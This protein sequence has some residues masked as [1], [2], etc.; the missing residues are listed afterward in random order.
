L[1]STL[2]CDGT[3]LADT[4]TLD[5]LTTIDTTTAGL[6]IDKGNTGA[7]IFQILFGF[8][9]AAQGLV[10]VTVTG[11]GTAGDVFFCSVTL[12]TNDDWEIIA[13]GEMDVT[14]TITVELNDKTDQTADG[15]GAPDANVVC[16]VFDRT[17]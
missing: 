11:A 16:I 14:G 6:R 9:L 7:T 10:D 2:R 3:E 13:L 12:D 4:I 15:S 5:T 17:T 8:A 1:E